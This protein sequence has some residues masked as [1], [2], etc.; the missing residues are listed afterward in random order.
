MRTL[1]NASYMKNFLLVKIGHHT[2]MGFTA[3][4]FLSKIAFKIV[5]FP[6]RIGI[7]YDSKEITLFK[8][9][10]L[11]LKQI[12]AIE[13]PLKIMRNTFYFI[14]TAFFDFEIFTFLSCPEVM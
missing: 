8:D 2:S 1:Y 10:L 3:L 7:T 14:L 13:N 5:S 6:T 9:P 4:I 11:N 12:Q